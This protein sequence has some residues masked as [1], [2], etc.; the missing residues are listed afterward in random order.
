MV[1]PTRSPN[2]PVW[3]FRF[4][5]LRAIPAIT[6]IPPPPSRGIPLHPRV[7]QIGVG[8]SSSPPL[9]EALKCSREIIKI[10]SKLS[11]CQAKKGHG[12]SRFNHTVSCPKMSPFR[13][14]DPGGRTLGLEPDS[15]SIGI[16]RNLPSGIQ[17]VGWLEKIVMRWL[18]ELKKAGL[19]KPG[20]IEAFDRRDQLTVMLADA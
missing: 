10:T 17:L 16:C 13:T 15:G 9:Q 2:A 7:S 1:I 14:A 18:S 20:L 5:R 6:E 19:V 12:M 11:E 8:F 4:Q 3:V